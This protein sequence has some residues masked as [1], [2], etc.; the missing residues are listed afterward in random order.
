[1]AKKIDQLLEF[2]EKKGFDYDQVLD[3]KSGETIATEI[4]TLYRAEMSSVSFAK[5]IKNYLDETLVK[6]ISS[7]ENGQ[8]LNIEDTI[9]LAFN[10]FTKYLQ[11]QPYLRKNF[12]LKRRYK[13]LKR[14]LLLSLSERMGSKVGQSIPI[15]GSFQISPFSFAPE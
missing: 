5:L 12:L 8:E 11:K 14:G 4:L 15:S 6:N 3:S 2:N 13:F 7:I 1:M 9:N 10:E